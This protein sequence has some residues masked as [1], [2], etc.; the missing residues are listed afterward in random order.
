MEKNSRG[1]SAL[2][3]PAV[4]IVDDEVDFTTALQERLDLDGVISL[5]ANSGYEAIRMLWSN[6]QI[7]VVVSDLVM[8]D[9]S[10]FDVM[11]IAST[12]APERDLKWV[13]VSGKAGMDDALTALR[14]RA[15]DFFRKP[16]DAE[17]VVNSVRRT[18]ADSGC[19]VEE[20][21]LSG[22]AR[23][24]N[25]AMIIEIARLSGDLVAPELHSMKTSLSILSETL[26]AAE[27]GTMPSLTS[28]GLD[29]QESIST[30]TRR[31]HTLVDSG[32]LVVVPDPNDQ[33]RRLITVNPG[34]EKEAEKVLTQL[35]RALADS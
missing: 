11:R 9:L 18:L 23:F 22:K 5:S 10:G 26:Q 20:A 17:E 24:S 7:S 34:L 15:V 35:R 16:V 19:L 3:Q 6:P 31:I 28:V 1:V 13:F 33:R 27:A 25:L 30:V 29:S 12:V 21:P 14:S 2:K 4:M 32:L 8:P